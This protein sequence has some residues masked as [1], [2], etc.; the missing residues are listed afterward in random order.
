M[1][2]KPVGWFE[3]YVQDMMRA[4]AFYGE[5]FG[6]AFEKLESP[7][8]AAM[9][10]WA[11]PGKMDDG[12]GASGA[13]VRMN[14]GPAGAGGTIVYFMG[15]DCA[16]EAGRVAASGGQ[17]IQPKFAIGQYGHA[18]MATDTEDNMIGLHSMQ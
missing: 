15:D 2:G 4:K 13:L 8:P 6:F 1:S 9:E 10:L 12:R 5:V 11:F 17:L 14:D 7:D 3:I 16:V 18:A